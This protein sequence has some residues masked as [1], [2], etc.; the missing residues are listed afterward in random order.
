MIYHLKTLTKDDFDSW[1]EALKDRNFKEPSPDQIIP[2]IQSNS[3]LSTAKRV[4]SR[5]LSIYNQGDKMLK[6]DIEQGVD[7]S[8]NHQQTVNQ[9]VQ[10]LEEIKQYLPPEI[11]GRLEHQKVMVISGAQEQAV[12]WLNAQNCLLKNRGSGS[13]SPVPTQEDAILEGDEQSL[14]RSPSFYS[15]TSGYSDQFFDAQ[16]IDLSEDEDDFIV[17]QTS[18]ID[19]DNASSEEDTGKGDNVIP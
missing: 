19:Y 17:D 3:S 9:L 13:V 7:M 4:S 16:D 18:S 10:T 11:L 12:Q 1:S 5:N 6:A 2:V 8:S 14:H 15:Q